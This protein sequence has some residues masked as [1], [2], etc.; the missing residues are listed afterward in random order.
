MWKEVIKGY[1]IS[2]E[3]QLRS[4]KTN[5]V[6]KNHIHEKGY[7]RTSVK[8]IKPRFIHR[9][10]GIAFIPNPLN[11]PQINHIDGNKQNNNVD[12]LEW[13]TNQYNSLH[14][15]IANGFKRPNAK[16]E[17]AQVIEIKGLLSTYNT[18]TLAQMFGVSNITIQKIKYGNY[19][20]DV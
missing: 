1:S 5:K 15:Y 16:L 2:T 19:W 4:D 7:L 6:L 20:K 10:V 12:N 9:L 3:G 11:L 14:Y 17:R 18:K 13:C 8:G